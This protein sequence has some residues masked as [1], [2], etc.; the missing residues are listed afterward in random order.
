MALSATAKLSK[1]LRQGQVDSGQIVK[2]KRRVR[3]KTPIFVREQRAVARL[4]GL[5]AKRP[6]STS[7]VL[8]ADRQQSPTFCLSSNRGMRE[9]YGSFRESDVGIAPAHPSAPDGKPDSL[10]HALPKLCPI[11]WMTDFEMR[12]SAG[13]GTL[14]P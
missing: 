6:L 8:K 12:E 3:L 5:V 1:R 2:I 11:K 4:S 13:L 14:K 9:M 7:C 10:S